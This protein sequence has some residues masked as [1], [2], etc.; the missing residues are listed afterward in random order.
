MGVPITGPTYTY[1]DYM[2]VGVVHNGCAHFTQNISRNKCVNLVR[3]AFLFLYGTMPIILVF[4][5]RNPTR[6]RIL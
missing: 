1:G 4:V 5:L 2:L 3:E 6:G